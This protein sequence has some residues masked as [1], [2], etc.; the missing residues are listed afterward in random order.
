[1]DTSLEKISKT[2][3]KI[4]KHLREIASNSKKE[5]EAISL[6]SLSQTVAEALEAEI[7]RNHR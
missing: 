6:E 5:P 4:E 1:M 7:E 2:L 3:D